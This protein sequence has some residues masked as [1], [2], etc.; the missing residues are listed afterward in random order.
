MGPIHSTLIQ[1]D[2]GSSSTLLLPP[3]ETRVSLLL[4]PS[5]ATNYSVATQPL[6]AVGDGINLLTAAGPVLLRREEF[7]D[8]VCQ[9]WY[10]IA[11]TPDRIGVLVAH[12]DRSV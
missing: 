6:V 8:L 9:A 11:T 4:T 5:P 10:A 2:V 3:S 1:V 7:G 12:E